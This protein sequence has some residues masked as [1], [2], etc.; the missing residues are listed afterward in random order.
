MTGVVAIAVNLDQVGC[1]MFL[2]RL[3]SV[4]MGGMGKPQEAVL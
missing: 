2:S 4:D 3:N 1:G